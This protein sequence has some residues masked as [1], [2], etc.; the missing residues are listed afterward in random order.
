MTD[1]YL[2]GLIGSGIQRSLTP[3]M[4]EREAERLGLR[5]MYLIIDLE[6]RKLSDGYL[7][8]MIRYGRL[9]GFRGFNV[10]HPC[11]QAVV[12]L[13][14]ELA[15]SAAAVGAV[16][17]VVF[18]GGRAIGHNTD[19]LG[20]EQNLLRGLPGVPLTKVVLLGAGGAGA[21]VA[22]ALLGLGAERLVVVDPDLQRLDT[23]AAALRGRFDAER[24]SVAE[25]SG[26]A[27]EIRDARGLVNA[28]P[29]GM[30]THPGL[31]LDAGLLRPG[32]WVAD[33]VYRP[34]ETELLRAARRAGCPTLDGGRMA[35][36]QAVG[37]FELFTGVAPDADR[38][39]NHFAELAAD[40]RFNSPGRASP[41]SA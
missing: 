18:D 24:F 29:V 38:M 2:V 20:F 23:L 35:V 28:T 39:L 40:Q 6:G 1:R 10:T 34:L 11:K 36:F 37:S 21:A 19:V 30:A 33:I 5:Y 4:H 13:L 32:L 31:P 27:H 25:P 41:R 3:P 8:G 22:H 14:D 17:T 15:P 26:L 16:N 9:L 12:P 7:E